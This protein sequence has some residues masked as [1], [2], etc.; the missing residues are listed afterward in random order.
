MITYEERYSL[1]LVHKS[2]DT[3]YLKYF[4]IAD[5]YPDDSRDELI[6]ALIPEH[7]TSLEEAQANP[8]HLYNPS[9]A[10]YYDSRDSDFYLLQ[11]RLDE[12]DS[13]RQRTRSHHDSV[14]LLA[15]DEPFEVIP[16]PELGGEKSLREYLQ[17]GIPF[18][19]KTTSRF[20]LVYEQQGR[21]LAAIRC[22]R[23]DF[24]IKDGTMKLAE[25]YANPRM[26]VISAPAVALN[27]SEVLESPHKETGP[28]FVYSKT[29]ELPE[30][31]RV[32]LR[33][34]GYYA[35]DYTKW[36][37][38]E[39][40]ISL[41]KSERRSVAHIVES[42]LDRPD[43]IEAYLDAGADYDEVEDLKKAVS[44]YIDGREDYAHD[45]VV[46]ALIENDTIHDRCVREILETDKAL[47][48]H[49]EAIEAEER[50]IDELKQAANDLE[51]DVE[52]LRLA[53]SEAQEELDRVLLD[54]ST[55]TEE[56][57]AVLAELEE[58]VALRIGLKVTS[59]GTASARQ[60]IAFIE[61]CEP[62]QLRAGNENLPRTVAANLK[63]LGVT[64]LSGNPDEVRGKLGIEVLVAASCARATV[65]A[66]VRGLAVADALSIALD[67]RT[68]DRVFVPSDFCDAG[69]IDEILA[70]EGQVIVLENVIDS[71]NEALLFH[72]LSTETEKIIFLPFF[73]YSNLSLVAKEA[74]SEMF[75]LGIEGAVLIG[76]GKGREMHTWNGDDAFL[77][78]A[79]IDV[80]D[81]MRVAKDLHDEIEGA[82]IPD[83]S[84]ILPATLLA[85]L[86]EDT[87]EDLEPMVSQHLAFVALRHAGAEGGDAIE[88]WS[89]GDSGLARLMK[90][91]VE[92]EG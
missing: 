80:D 59:S 42:A 20:Y 11:W 34:L 49:R 90:K 22:A 82:P 84:L 81:I 73:S 46:K 68:A 77:S 57:E 38:R 48:G 10:L 13:N 56:A 86:E 8:N 75:L 18:A 33:P 52:K 1:C 30:E 88:K 23:K 19:G 78:D 92:N 51:A 15:Y 87:E 62:M 64:S 9:A 76:D 21:E 53:Q 27:T 43:M 60:S 41:S 70:G 54:L 2:E 7:T 5:Y 24:V 25:N 29:S 35:A 28:R 55:S 71:V 36:F 91:A 16:L 58:N 61:G 12:R 67:G 6:P 37:I 79:P 83:S 85:C 32:L 4:R 65:A 45:V 26:S 39:Q 89:P 66:D 69:E 40:G 50:R 47:E 74:W 63:Q 14:S 3:G 31:K 17:K 72:L 44:N